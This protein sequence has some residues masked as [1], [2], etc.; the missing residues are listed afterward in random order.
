MKY[1]PIPENEPR[2]LGDLA[3]W[4]QDLLDRARQLVAD[5]RRPLDAVEEVIGAAPLAQILSVALIS[6]LAGVLTPEREEAPTQR[7]H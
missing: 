4:S 2:A 3:E 6:L 5:G 1:A 7:P